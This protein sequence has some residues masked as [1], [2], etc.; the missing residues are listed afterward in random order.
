MAY[1]DIQF[2]SSTGGEPRIDHWG[3]D[4]AEAFSKGDV[5]VLAATG[6]IQEALTTGPLPAG[7]TGIAM[8][9][10]IGPGAITINNPRTG[11][12]YAENDRLPVALFDI[13]SRW[14]TKNYTEGTAFNDAAPT[15]ANIGDE[16]GLVSISGVW[17]VDQGMDTNEA[18]GRITDILNVRKESIQDTGQTLA[19]T[20]TYW[21]VFQV[22]AHQGTPDS[23]EAPDPISET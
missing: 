9:G 10:S 3:M 11:T 8:A 4:A 23:A 21:V 16:I 7:L 18:I 1:D 13:N 17:G 14:I 22:V 2:H 6:Q 12:T 5:V 19:T 15:R 20:D